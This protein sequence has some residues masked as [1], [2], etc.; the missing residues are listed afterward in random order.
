MRRLAQLSVCIIGAG[1]RGVSVLERICANARQLA[2]SPMISVHVVD[3]YRPGAGRVWRT[4]QSPHLLMNTVASQVTMFT[5]E[6]VEI[7]GPVTPG[8]SLY[9]WARLMI[10]SRHSGS[11][12]EEVL[13]EARRL[14]P[15]T[16]PTRAFYGR[17]LEWVFQRIVWGAPEQVSVMVH[18]DRAVSLDDIGGP[19]H[20]QTVRLES[21][22]R[23]ERMDAVVLAQGHLGEQLGRAEAEFADFAAAS[24]LAYVPPANP[25]DVDLSSVP[26]GEPVLLRGLGLN[27][28][29]YLALLTV[30]RGGRFESREGGL[31]YQPSGAE[32][33]LYAG[34]RR[35][36]PYH[37]RGENEKGAYGRHLPVL[38]TSTTVE[39]L[40]KR[41]ARDGGLDFRRDLW[42]LVA[43]EVEVVYY[44]ALL[45]ARGD[46]S[47]AEALRACY[48]AAPRRE[49]ELA[50]LLDDFRIE[51]EARWLWD[52]IADPS[53]GRSFD[54]PDEFRAWLLDHLRADVRHARAGNVSGPLKAALDVLRDLRNEIRL[55][56]DHG[57]LTGDSY[58][59]DL[60][61]WYTPLNAFLSIGPPASR[62]VEMIALIE[63]GVLQVLGP[64]LRVEVDRRNGRFVA[65]SERVP[66]AVASCTAMIEARL[67]TPS[68]RRTT[69]PLT[70]HLLATKQ[71]TSYWI[72]TPGG[73]PYETGGLAVT[74]R[75]Y[76]LLD[77]EGR[78]HP[79]RFAFGVPTESVHW[80]TAAGVR[81][82]VNSVTLC[83]SDAIARAVL[84]L[85]REERRESV[86]IPSR[87]GVTT[88]SGDHHGT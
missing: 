88:E 25:A 12:D 30:G 35:G 17:Y 27:F 87:G 53:D 58:R 57:G 28:F 61:R 4:T 20:G 49:A 80:V 64:G 15:D 74:D 18:Q 86:V 75:P 78:E 37:A 34:S 13:R 11:Y 33:R 26:A 68:L 44:T 7:D 59:D 60:D 9:E 6:S 76:H 1:P 71:C 22:A 10:S 2:P 84:A 41:A 31:T 40:R 83:D 62:V 24:G 73:T 50:R 72:P 48:L 77:V 66:G 42:P 67:P 52:R 65:R 16:Y 54:G 51:P 45:K 21:G 36:M 63:A 85:A 70:H 14:G 19:T 43:T 69:D 56:V 8:P 81:P 23:L 29:D 46:H 79:R 82:G 47:A 5:D 55:L 38:L 39:Q 32:P 3:S